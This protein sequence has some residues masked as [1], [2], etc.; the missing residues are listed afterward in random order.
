MRNQ[1]ASQQQELVV[2]YHHRRSTV[3]EFAPMLCT[4]AESSREQKSQADTGKPSE[5]Q[6]NNSTS[7]Y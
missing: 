6:N 4:I 5:D 7:A 3:E 2:D 1:Y